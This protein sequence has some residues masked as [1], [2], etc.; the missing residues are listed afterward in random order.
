MLETSAE[1]AV[2]AAADRLQAIF[3]SRLASVAIYGSAAGVD[4]VPGVS[5]INLAAVVDDL[6]YHDLRA[7][8]THVARWRKQRIATPLLLDRRFLDNAVDVFP[9]ELHDIQS[10]HRTLIGVDV[11]A[12]LAVHDDHLRYQC[13][14]EA[15][16]KV[17]RL[18][19]LYLEIG[20]NRR[21]LRSLMLDSLKTFLIVM[22]TLNRMRGGDKA[23]PYAEGL[24][25][26]CT[27][28]AC[29]FPVMSRLLQV[30]LAK[31][32]WQGDEEVLFGDYLEELQDL[33]RIIDQL[34]PSGASAEGSDNQS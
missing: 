23:V 8:R 30:K 11:F 13:E 25:I 28:Y 24:E 31:E 17:L 10:Q 16:G 22:R 4:Y 6:S 34:P 1:Q 9:M 32:K 21:Q 7:V 33:V 29:S 20:E 12:P 14:H 2:S 5:D 26:F 27:R 3:G 19:E 18:R 15:R